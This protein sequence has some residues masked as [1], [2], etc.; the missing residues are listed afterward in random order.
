MFPKIYNDQN[1][2]NAN[3]NRLA[4]P[5]AVPEVAAPPESVAPLYLPT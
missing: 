2:R 3:A 1:D 5:N 4:S